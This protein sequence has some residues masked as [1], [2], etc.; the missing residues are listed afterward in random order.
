MIILILSIS[1]LKIT[2]IGLIL[3]FC[4][5]TSFRFP[6]L[7]NLITLLHIES[8]VTVLIIL[9]TSFNSVSYLLLLSAKSLSLAL[10]III[11]LFFKLSPLISEI[12]LLIVFLIV[13]SI[14]SNC[15]DVISAY[16]VLLL[17]FFLSILS[18]FMINS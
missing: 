13:L 14:L 18:I 12:F 17:L 1:F 5:F 11:D 3:L 4:I 2:F 10:Y 9:F 8:S 15:L 7:W 6:N 16:V